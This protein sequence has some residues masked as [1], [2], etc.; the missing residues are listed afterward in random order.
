MMGMIRERTR[1]GSVYYGIHD[2]RA[3]YEILDREACEKITGPGAMKQEN[4]DEQDWSLEE[5]VE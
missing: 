1:I 2:Y 3:R 5:E 4:I